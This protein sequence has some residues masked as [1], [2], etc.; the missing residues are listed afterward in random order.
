[1][2]NLQV[3]AATTV[4]TAIYETPMNACMKIRR[5]AALEVY[6]ILVRAF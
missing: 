3:V 1:M 2:R 4:G 6:V 5:M